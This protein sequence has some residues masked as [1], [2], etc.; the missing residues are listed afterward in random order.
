MGIQV[1]PDRANIEFDCAR[2]SIEQ[3]IFLNKKGRFDVAGI[4]VREHGGPVGENEP[5]DTHPARYT[6]RVY[7]KM[8]S[9]TVTLTDTME[10]I[11]SF[12]LI[13]GQSPYVT[14]CL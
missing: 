3:P 5:P 8:M 13:Y 6:G 12:T 4:F 14:K 2:G 7:R 10:T 9:I 1:E 11:G